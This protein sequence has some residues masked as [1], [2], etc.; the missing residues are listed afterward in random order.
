[1]A[2]VFP[3]SDMQ[4][5]PTAWKFEGGPRADAPVSFFLTHTP[6]GKGPGLHVHPYPEVFL[7][8]EGT[9]TFRVGGEQLEV[10][11]GH[12]VVV[13]PETPHGF[14]NHG[15]G[16]LRQ[17]SIHPNPEVVQTWLEDD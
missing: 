9:A 17:V 12:V 13:P 8:Q 3:L 1:M 6:P 14:K 5:S 16:T 11:A 15:E 2:P 7:V 4:T 10:P